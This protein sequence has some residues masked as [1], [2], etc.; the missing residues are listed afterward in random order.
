MYLSSE[1]VAFG[2][3]FHAAVAKQADARDL[4]SLGVKSVPVQVRSAAPTNVYKKDIMPTNGC[5]K[6]FVGINLTKNRNH[7]P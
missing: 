1:G 4:K 7:R 3:L 6:P 5:T 2:A